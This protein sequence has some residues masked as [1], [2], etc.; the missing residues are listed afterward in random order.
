MNKQEY[1][2]NP[3]KASPLSFWKTCVTQVPEHMLIV[4][5]DDFLESMLDYYS[6]EPY[7]KLLHNLG[8]IPDYKLKEPFVFRDA[9]IEDYASHINSC[10]EY[11]GITAEEL[12]S[13]KNRTVYDGDLWVSIYDTKNQRIAATGI[14]EFDNDIKE[15]YLDWIQVSSEY[16]GLGLGQAVVMELLRRLQEKASF[17][18]VSG[19]INNPTNPE[20]LYKRCG[21]GSKVV[22]HILTK[23]NTTL[24]GGRK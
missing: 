3:T 14:A 12:A 23:K 19:R 7:F 1:L 13:Y 21:F 2:Q 5:E 22:W 24:F 6:D 9:T 16:R 8:F 15:G 11:E 10:Y 4:N 17:V 18:T 20:S